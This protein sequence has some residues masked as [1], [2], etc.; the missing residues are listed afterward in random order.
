MSDET[1][2]AALAAGL[3]EPREPHPLSVLFVTPTLGQWADEYGESIIRTMALLGLEG[4]PFSFLKSYG[5][6]FIGVARDQLATA[7]LA[8]PELGVFQNLFWI[9]DDVGWPAEKVL[10]FLKAPEPI[11]AGVPRLKKEGVEYPWNPIGGHIRVNSVNSNPDAGYSHPGYVRNE[12]G[13]YSAEMVPM[14]FCRIKREALIQVA[15]NVPRY[16]D[17]G[18]NGLTEPGTQQILALFQDGPDERGVHVGEDVAFCRLARHFGVDIWVDADI[19]FS[20]RGSYAF[21]GKLA[22]SL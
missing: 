18:K 9:D 8:R 14:G 11:L 1:A 12:R 17:D 2:A 3:D 6:T 5:K 20:H 10:E 15:R 7:W 21:R 16:L 4:I 22:D 13:M 19:E